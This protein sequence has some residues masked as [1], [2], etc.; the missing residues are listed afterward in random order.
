MGTVVFASAQRRPEGN[1]AIPRA[2]QLKGSSDWCHVSVRAQLSR[3][4]DGIVASHACRLMLVVFACERG[5]AVSSVQFR[6]ELSM[7]D[8]KV[9]DR[10][11]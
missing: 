9:R 6:N 11:R 2:Q 7:A 3:H 5:V 4:F 8:Q 1:E 10:I